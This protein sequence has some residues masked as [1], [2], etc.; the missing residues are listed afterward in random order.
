MSREKHLRRKIGT[1]LERDREA[2]DEKLRHERDQTDVLAAE[3]AGRDDNPRLG[4]SAP[5]SPSS[6]TTPTSG[7]LPDLAETLAE[8]AENLAEAAAG[9]TR[10]AEKLTETETEEDAALDTLHD[11]VRSLDGTAGR[12][13]GTD[14]SDSVPPTAATHEEPE[15]V[16]AGKL[17]DVAESLGLVAASLAD[18][19]TQ[20]DE[21]LRDERHRLDQTLEAERL[22]MENEREQQGRLLEEERRQTDVDLARERADTDLAIDQTFNLLREEEE[23]HGAA[24]DMMVTREEFLAIVSHDLRTP[25]SVI[26]VSAAIIKERV[27]TVEASDDLLRAAERIQRSA[28][29]MGRMLSDLLDATRFQ[30]GQFRLSPGPGDVTD[31]VK[32]CLAAFD[33]IACAHDVSLR[34]D[35]PQ[36]RVQARF[37]HDRILQVLSNLVRNALQF[38]GSGGLVTLRVVPQPHGCRIEVSDTG[39]GIPSEDLQR[40]FDRFHQAGNADRRGLGLGLYISRAIVEAHGGTIW[41]DSTEGQGSTFSFT[42]PA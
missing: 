35:V 18:E 11:V 31:T 6:G 17:A 23:A 27:P 8:A 33:A 19:R 32:E 37:D 21:T 34:L 13:I 36:A 24:R 12:V 2:T 25:L 3:V 1:V 14:T 38:T 5:A 29:Q 42:L 30:H 22:A 9:L 20:A 10:A 26:A 28:D 7:S 39:T 41:A 4:D 40:I 16:V 15:P